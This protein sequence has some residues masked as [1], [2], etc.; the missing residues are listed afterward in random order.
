MKSYSKRLDMLEKQI[1][2]NG[3]NRE[4]LVCR[5]LQAVSEQRSMDE[6]EYRFNKLHDLSQDAVKI[7]VLEG[8]ANG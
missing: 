2:K 1:A 7:H 8:G 5:Y 6:L 3:T 4:K